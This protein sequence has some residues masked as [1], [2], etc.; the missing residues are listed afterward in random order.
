MSID[1][2]TLRQIEELAADER[3]LLVLDVDDVLLDF[4]KPFPT[5]LQRHGCRLDFRSF[6]LTGN[7]IEIATEVAVE[8]P[9]VR[10]LLDG[11]F[12]TQTDWQTLVED[13]ADSLKMIARDAEIVLLTAMPHRHRDTRRRHLD[14]LGLTYPLLTTEMA[15]GPAV[16]RLRGNTQRPVAFVDDMLHNLA[17]AREHVADAHLFHLVA[18]IRLREMQPPADAGIHVVDNW[19]EASGKIAVALGL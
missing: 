12:D 5:Y 9:R 15:K 4:I 6:R 10:E 7:I 13:A 8:Q 18:D 19:R 14:G 2:E 17:S 11:F 1:P 3:P 16:R